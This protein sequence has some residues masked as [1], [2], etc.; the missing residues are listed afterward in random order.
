MDYTEYMWLLNT[1]TYKLHLEQYPSRAVYAIL[2]H[3]WDRTG[4]EQ[5]FQLSA[6][7]VRCCQ[8]ARSKGFVFVWIDTCC[9][10]KTSSAELSEAIN[11]MFDWY[12]FATVCY[13]YLDDVPDSMSPRA[14]GSSFRY[15][16]WFTRGWTLQEL[17]VPHRNIF[18]S[19]DWSMIGTKVALANVIETITGIDSA[20]LLRTRP[21]HAVSVARRMSW[22]VHRYTTRIEDE[23]YCLMGIF[24]VRFPAVYGEGSQAF[25][26]LQE[27]I[28]KRLPD[29]SLLAWGHM[30]PLHSVED[31]LASLKKAPVGELRA[32]K[33]AYLFPSSP[34]DF[35]YS[36]GF[37]PIPLSTL[38]S[39][40]GVA[41]LDPPVCLPTSYGIRVT[42][43]I[44]TPPASS[45]VEV[46]GIRLG[47]LACEDAQ[48]RIPALIVY[49]DESNS[50][51][52]VG[53][54][55][56]LH[57][58]LCRWDGTIEPLEQSA[59][60]AL[61]A[62]LPARRS[63]CRRSISRLEWMLNARATEVRHSRMYPRLALL[64]PSALRNAIARRPDSL[65][66]RDVYIPYRRLQ[67]ES[68]M[69]V[70]GRPTA[71][72]GKLEFT[73]PCSITLPRWTL[74]HL[75]ERGVQ[76]DVDIQGG[77]MMPV[78]VPGSWPDYLP[79]R[80]VLR[81]SAASTAV[82]TISHC[83]NVT[84]YRA[85]LHLAVSWNQD[86]P[87]PDAGIPQVQVTHDVDCAKDHVDAWPS[88]RK[89]FEGPLEGLPDVI[90][91]LSVWDV[92]PLSAGLDAFEEYPDGA[93]YSLE[94]QFEDR[95]SA[96]GTSEMP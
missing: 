76:F 1:L 62:S 64:E 73:A 54:F 21:L 71:D 63:T 27:E 96:H 77:E 87:S 33:S 48:G 15:S 12:S 9:I 56:P 40:L 50:T 8:Y 14:E 26:R 41:P 81:H 29:Q 47:A 7:I 32:S 79:F 51:Y 31:D 6:K 23:A 74:A 11:S 19:Q 78:P 4:A 25:V 55:E 60:E 67:A 24:G 18:L 75:E 39:R 16:A 20:V 17:I 80:L 86:R 49:P 88:G 68:H 5:T 89:R 57:S 36:A 13:V 92:D 91:Q 94:I 61:D 38:A 2:S 35:Q 46:T 84:E 53:G 85:P 59:S 44:Y 22:A 37:S 93:C 66:V 83:P 58:Y 10:D 42:L 70:L 30:W 95:A 65:V 28:M 34:A 52:L 90:A 45:A 82:V 72:I 3:V 69:T 43:P